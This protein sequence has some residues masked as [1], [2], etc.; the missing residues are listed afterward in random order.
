VIAIYWIKFEIPNL[1][2]S[3]ADGKEKKQKV[4]RPA[5]ESLPFSGNE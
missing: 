4:G 2:A 1:T 3:I 5:E